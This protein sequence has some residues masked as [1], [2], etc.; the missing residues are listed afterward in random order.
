MEQMLENAER[1]AVQRFSKLCAVEVGHIAEDRPAVLE[2][3]DTGRPESPNTDPIS[4]M[5]D[6]LSSLCSP[7]AEQTVHPGGIQGGFTAT[8]IPTAIEITAASDPTSRPNITK[9]CP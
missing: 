2:L 7:T 9:R 6:V 5:Y 8:Q 1:N 4:T 3:R